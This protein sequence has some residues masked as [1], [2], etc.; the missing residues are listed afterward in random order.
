LNSPAG[1][2]TL[3]RVKWSLSN[4]FALSAALAVGGCGRNPPALPGPAVANPY[5]PVRAQPRLPTITLF[6]D[7]QTLT[8]EICRA[9]VEI[10]TG[11]MF[12]TN[13]PPDECMLFVFPEAD[14]RAF[15]MKN[16][17]VPLSA[18]YLDPD[19]VIREIHDL[20]PGD[21]VS[22]PTESRQIQYVIEA[23]QGWFDQHR[24]KAGT[25]VR[26]GR[27]TLRETFFPFQP[28]AAPR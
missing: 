25:V 15:W 4:A 11:M 18:A 22:V 6:L 8:A 19:G 23:N 13:L 17:V 20:L 28:P 1:S 7:Q 12:R 2:R 21:T 9:P 27:G 16:C 10:M 24:L 26:T 5:E 3:R 14:R